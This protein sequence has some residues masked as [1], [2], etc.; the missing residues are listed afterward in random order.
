MEK[1]KAVKCVKAP[2]NPSEAVMRLLDDFRSMVNC[3]IHVGLEKN[4][5]SRF[6]IN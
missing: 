1:A 4:I 2:Y 5:T 6:Q 3:C